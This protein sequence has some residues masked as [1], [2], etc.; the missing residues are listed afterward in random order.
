VGILTAERAMGVT[1]ALWAG[2]D[3]ALAVRY[4]A[5]VRRRWSFAA[6]LPSSA[7]MKRRYGYRRIH[8]LLCRE[9]WS[10]NHKRRTVCTVSRA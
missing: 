6:A 2:G 7:A 10:V 8:V 3:L 4:R 1:R 5:A 9:G